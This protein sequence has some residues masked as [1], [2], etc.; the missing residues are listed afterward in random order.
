MATAASPTA[1]LR[2]FLAKYSPEIA[3]RAQA[4][5]KK[6]RTR[7]PSALE[8]VYDNYNALAIG[9]WPDANAPRKSSFPSP[10]IPI[11]SIYFS[12]RAKVCPTRKNCCTAT[13][14]VC[15]TFARPHPKRS[16]IPQ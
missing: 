2:A 14:I 6:M 13:A 15:A 8:L 16:T 11:G 5:L 1:Q 4:I 7:Y 12:C 9:F 10:S 3:A